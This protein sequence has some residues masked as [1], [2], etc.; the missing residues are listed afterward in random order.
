M[1]QSLKLGGMSK[2]CPQHEA[3]EVVKQMATRRYQY[4]PKRIY[5]GWR[6]YSHDLM[7]ISVD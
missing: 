4:F 5:C 6:I 3:M 7:H 2:G 1:Y